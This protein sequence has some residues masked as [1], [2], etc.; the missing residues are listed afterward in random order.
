MKLVVIGGT[1]LIGSK[2]VARLSEQGHEAVPAAPDTGVNTL[3]GEGLAHALQGASVVV[4]V[5]NSPSFEERAVMAFFTT[6]T[7]NL[8]EY[9]AAAGV[10]HYVA[11]SVV[12]TERIP[13]SPYLRAKN[14]QET[15]IK[16]AGIPYSIIHA[17]QFFEFIKRIADEASD[18]TTVRLPPVLIQPMAADDVAQAVATVA[19]SAP[20]NGMVEV[21][22][23]QQ[24]RFDELIR[25]GLRARNDLREI[26]VDPHAQYFGAE[27]AERSLLPADGARLGE[28][29]LQEWLGQPVLQQR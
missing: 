24:F 22:G 19:V 1:G 25:Q 2:L 20:L 9:A 15:L 7:R 13:D 28:I 27:L 18:G 14:A 17:T 3:T 23:P 5:S 4:D 12:G 29:R 16:A 21:A 8:L 6:S 10:R 26:V 11:L